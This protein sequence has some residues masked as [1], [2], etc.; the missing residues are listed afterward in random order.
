[1]RGML[2][3]QNDKN[4]ATIVVSSNAMIAFLQG[5]AGKTEPGIV[6]IDVHGVGYKVMMPTGDWDKLTEGE[7]CKLHISSYIREDRF[8][9]YGFADDRS[10]ALFE[11]LIDIAGI[12]PRTGLE[13]C[14]IPR[15]I[16]SQAVFEKDAAILTAVKGIGRKSA[17]KLLVELTS[18]MEKNPAL[19]AGS[20][21]VE[22]AVSARFD[23]DAAAA[24]G[25]LGFS[26]EEIMRALETLPQDL[27]TT[28]ERVTAA[29][30]SL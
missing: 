7:Q 5:I 15:S 25:Q 6:V 24:L 27:T 3:P 22:G 18:L 28:E 21:S 10:R 29:L 23:R 26:S 12:G 1:M 2:C 19:F 17:E 11:K 4:T 14:S 20:G 9:L 8:D 16:L 13:L 30:R